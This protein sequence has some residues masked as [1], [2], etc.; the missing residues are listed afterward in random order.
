MPKYIKK[1]PTRRPSHPGEVLK[2][3]WLN[4]LE[5]SQS[6]F[7]EELVKVSGGRVKKTTM[8]TKLNEVISGKRSMS[9]EFAVLISRV[10]KTDPKMWMNLQVQLDIWLAEEKV[11]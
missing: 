6:A 4:E 7:A 8:Q 11:A 1:R 5:Y 9:A 10:L 2:N 3:I